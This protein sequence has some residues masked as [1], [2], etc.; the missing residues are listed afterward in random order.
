MNTTLIITGLV[1]LSILTLFIWGR[2]K[3]KSIPLTGN[4]EKIMLLDDKNFHHQIR[5]KTVLVDF[6]AEWCAPCRM[7]APVLN[8]LAGELSDKNHLG[9]VDVEKN[10]TLARQF[11]IRSIPTM[12]LFRNG[13]EQ[14]R[15]VGVKSKDFLLKQIMN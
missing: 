6:W 2:I 8:D 14:K 13:K 7:M 4:H 10:Q 5:N 15:F 9:K 11:K 12:V 3:M 1:I